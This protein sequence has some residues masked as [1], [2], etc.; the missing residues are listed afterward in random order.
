MLRCRTTGEIQHT[1][2]VIELANQG[3][4]RMWPEPKQKFGNKK[5]LGGNVPPEARS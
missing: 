4:I 5:R 3:A 2:N 1:G